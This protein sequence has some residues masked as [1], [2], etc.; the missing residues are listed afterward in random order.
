MSQQSMVDA[1]RGFIEAYNDGDWQRMEAALTPN[2]S[3]SEVGS[4]RYVEG[5]REVAEFFQGWHRAM[6]DGRGTVDGVVA[7]EDSVAL[8]ITWRGTL[9][10]PLSAPGAVVEPTGRHQ[11]TRAAIILRFDRHAIR[12]AH[13][14]FDSLAL[15]QQLGVMAEPATA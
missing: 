7:G 14:Y 1:A 2:C 11:V 10:G 9:T 6:P 3:Y 8:E 4:G 5:A 13:H 15:F 12:E